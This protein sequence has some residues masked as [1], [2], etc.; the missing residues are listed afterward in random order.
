VLPA[1]R[2]ALPGEV[3]VPRLS[4]IRLGDLADAIG[5]EVIV[6]GARAGE[7]QHETLISA[8]ES[9]AAEVLGPRVFIG[10]AG[11]G[12]KALGAYESLSAPRLSVAELRQWIGEL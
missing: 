1:L 6:T 8:H 7:K 11:G 2:L 5:G 10:R 9:L 12:E 3:A 4:A